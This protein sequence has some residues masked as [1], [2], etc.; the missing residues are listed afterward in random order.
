MLNSNRERLQTYWPSSSKSACFLSCKSPR[1][2]SSAALRS[3]WI[4]M[5]RSRFRRSSPCEMPS[6]VLRSVVHA[7]EKSGHVRVV[8]GRDGRHAGV[9]IDQH[10]LRRLGQL[11][12]HVGAAGG[13]DQLSGDADHLLGIG[14]FGVLDGVE[15]LSLRLGALRR[16]GVEV[17]LEFREHCIKVLHLADLGVHQ[18]LH[19]RAE[20]PQARVDVAL[21]H[22]LPDLQLRSEPLLVRHE[23]LHALGGL[24]ARAL[25]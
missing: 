15:E 24:K 20:A 18:D 6:L 16:H 7:L 21:L 25:P 14:L 3:C 17:R 4:S 8:A 1:S 12:K 10:R 19:Q 5:T 11:V 9:A 2:S 22:L 23:V 13:V